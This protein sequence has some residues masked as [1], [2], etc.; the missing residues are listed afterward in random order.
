MATVF[1]V[2]MQKLDRAPSAGVDVFSRDGLD[3]M[4]LPKYAVM[5]ISCSDAGEGLFQASGLRN[6]TQG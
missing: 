6:I 2:S 5:L 1:E 3:V 4:Q